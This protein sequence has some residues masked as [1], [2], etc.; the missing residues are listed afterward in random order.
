MQRTSDRIIIVL[1]LA[2]AGY[3]LWQEP[4]HPTDPL[5]GK[6][7]MVG[8]DP[9][10]GLQHGDGPN[11]A[12]PVADFAGGGWRLERVTVV[13]RFA[14]AP[15]GSKTAVRLVETWN[16]GLHR[17][18]TTVSGVTPGAVHTLSL[19]VKADELAAIQFEM[20]DA[21]VGKYGLAHFNL[22]DKGVTFEG[23]DVSDA[24]LQALPDGWYRCW[25]AMPYSSD[26][27]VFNFALLGRGGVFTRRSFGLGGLLIW[28]VQFEPG[29]RPR[30][31]AGA[32][33]R[34]AQ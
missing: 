27:A 8:A 17:I 26:T 20:R 32:Q 2:L 15:D 30:G 23:G 22:Q 4:P 28:G 18:E 3:F 33:S 5:T 19:F 25:A 11:L 31:Y 12:S 7:P 13:P 14:V 16:E 34:A 9:V 6:L 1:L 10:P 21:R 29:D 24:G